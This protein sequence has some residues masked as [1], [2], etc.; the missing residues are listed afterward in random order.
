VISSR[1]W[2]RTAFY[3][4]SGAYGFRDQLQDVMGLVHCEPTLVREHLLRSAR[5]QFEEG[6]VQHWWHPPSGKGVRTRCS[7]DYL[8]LPFATSRYVEVTDD[9]GVLDEACPFLHSRPLQEGEMSNYELPEVSSESASLYEH[10]RR[11]IVNSRRY[12]AHGLPLMGAGD[13][14]DG[15]NLVGSGG[16]GESVWLA[17][18]LIAV[19]NR[20]API[21]RRRFDAAFADDCERDAASLAARIEASAWDGEWYLRAWTDGGT[22]IGSAASRECRIDSIAQSWS[23]LSGAARADRARAAMSSLDKH[24][25]R[26]ETRICQLLD[27]PFD[28]T[29][30]SPGYIQGY[31]PGVRENGGQYTHAAVWAAL[32][33]AAMGDGERAW[34]LFGFLDPIRHGD[35][36]ERI[37]VYKTEPYVVAG[38]VYAF[39]PHAG[40]GGWTWYTGSAGWLYRAGVESILGLRVQLDSLVI[41]PCIPTAW[42]KFSMTLRYRGAV[43]EITVHNPGNVSRGVVAVEIDGTPQAASGGKARVKLSQDRGVHA[44]LVTLGPDRLD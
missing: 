6:D 4:S 37:G 44:I 14:N 10:C 28:T 26:P 31:V 18:F 17:F 35:S 41:D 33:F 23:V 7:D 8:W 16:K 5:R 36:P 13:W 27:P 24:L 39:A 21:A 40:R 25:I 34:R 43:Y 11:A 42:P 1:L 9:V 32:A 19:L 38:D 20:F 22:K 3:Q 29:E 2:G 12:G 15:M 30:P